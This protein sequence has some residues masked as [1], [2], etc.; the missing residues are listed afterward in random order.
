[1]A[2]K[3]ETKRF[4]GLTAI[5]GNPGKGKTYFLQKLALKYLKQGYIVVLVNCGWDIEGAITIDSPK[6]LLGIYLNPN[7]RKERIALFT[8]EANSLFPSRD[9]AKTAQDS[10]DYFAMFR[11][12]GVVAFFYCTQSFG[13]VELLVRSKT[14]FVWECG[15]VRPLKLFHHRSFSK[16]DYEKKSAGQV[17]K[18]KPYGAT[19]F[20][21]RTLRGASYDTY[22][23][24]DKVASLAKQNPH[25][26]ALLEARDTIS[27]NPPLADAESFFQRL[28]F[29]V[30]SIFFGKSTTQNM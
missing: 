5:V 13:D 3:I 20:F 14:E 4:E 23:R 7:Q 30:R 21:A 1:M 22:A 16:S 18:Y 6:D 17:G 12:A 15:F 29:L 19:M 11:H 8:D 25:I 24:F 9:W 2:Q 27:A 26:K 10:R 28:L